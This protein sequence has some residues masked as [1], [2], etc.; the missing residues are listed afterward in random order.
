MRKPYSRQLRPHGTHCHI[1]CALRAVITIDVLRRAGAK[2]TIASVGNSL[3]VNCSRG[4]VLVA[5]AMIKDVENENFD[6]IA[7]PVSTWLM[8]CLVVCCVGGDTAKHRKVM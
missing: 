5:D 6:L 8:V 7:C 4:V 3:T 1:T 2:V